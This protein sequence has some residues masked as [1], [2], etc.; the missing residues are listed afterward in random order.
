MTRAKS[1]ILRGETRA[2]GRREEAKAAA[3]GNSNLPYASNTT[4]SGRRERNR[5]AICIKSSS[6]APAVQASPVGLTATSILFP[7]ASTPTYVPWG[8]AILQLSSQWL[9]QM[10]YRLVL[11]KLKLLRVL[12]RITVSPFVE[13]FREKIRGLTG[14]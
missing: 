1:R 6:P 11:L 10:E 14:N 5:S 4:R 3:T 7:L 13:L 2:K 12:P 8:I 9:T